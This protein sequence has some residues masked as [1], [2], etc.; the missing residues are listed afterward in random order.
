M[1]AASAAS[2]PVAAKTAPKCAAAPAP[3][4]AMTGTVTAARTD[5]MRSWS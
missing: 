1:P 4:D 5:A 3:D 2:T